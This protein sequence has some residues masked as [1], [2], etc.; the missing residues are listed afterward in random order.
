MSVSYCSNTSQNQQN[1]DELERIRKL[2]YALQFALN[3]SLHAEEFPDYFVFP[4]NESELVDMLSHN[5][6]T[7]LGDS[8][9]FWFGEHSEYEFMVVL[10]SSKD[11]GVFY[12]L[13]A[14]GL[15]PFAQEFS[16]KLNP[17]IKISLDKY[18]EG[19]LYDWV[20]FELTPPSVVWH[21]LKEQN[22]EKI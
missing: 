14:D 13:A 12:Y 4:K 22:I 7:H 15:R 19:K 5:K 17:Q 16:E 3:I 9:K 20:D 10:P 11:G 8:I 6:F 2:Q 21:E 1:I 18:S